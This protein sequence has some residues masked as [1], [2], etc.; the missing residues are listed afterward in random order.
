MRRVGLDYRAVQV[1]D[2]LPR[3]ALLDP[4]ARADAIVLPFRPVPS[5]APFEVEAAGAGKPLAAVAKR[6]RRAGAAPAGK[7]SGSR[8]LRSA[9]ASKT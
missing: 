8:G 3:Q 9:D 1:P 4:L 6:E 5:E 2:T 7:A